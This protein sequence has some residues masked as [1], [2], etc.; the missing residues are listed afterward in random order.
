LSS[1]PARARTGLIGVLVPLVYD[2]YFSAILSG[3]AEAAYEHRLRLV[4]SP[5]QHEHAREISLLDR[6]M[7]G[8]SDGALIILPEETSAE[9]ERAQVDGFPFVVIDPLMPLGDRIPSVSAAHRSGAEEAMQHLLGLGHARIA[10]V[11]GPPGWVATEERRAAYDAAL[12]AAGIARDPALV[13]GSDFETAPGAAAAARL[14][15]LPQPPTAIF[16]FNDSIAYGV[17]QAARQRGLRVPEDL[18]V[19]GFDDIRY[20]T[21]VAPPLTTVRQPLAE[22]GRTAVGVLLRLLDGQGVEAPH[23]E[24]ATRLVVRESTAPPR[25]RAR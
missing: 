13:V 1:S 22:M 12:D 20:S 25:A 4:L 7:R 9:L 16:A 18:S 8:V 21:V 14:L 15:D 5:T 2:I 24:L 11:C 10:A 3:A 19:V 6:L 23:I 17:L